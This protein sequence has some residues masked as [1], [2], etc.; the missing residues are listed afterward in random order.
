MIVQYTGGFHK[1]IF[2]FFFFYIP[3]AIAIS[4]HAKWSMIITGVFCLIG[5]GICYFHTPFEQHGYSNLFCFLHESVDSDDKL[6]AVK[7]SFDL[8]VENPWFK[9]VYFGSMVVHLISIMCLEVF[10]SKEK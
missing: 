4:Y 5:V 8:M 3:S 6:K 9:T 1:S 7:G 2:N 10:K